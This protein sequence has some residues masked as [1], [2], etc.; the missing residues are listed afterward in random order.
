MVLGV[1]HEADYSPFRLDDVIG[2]KG[3]SILSNVDSRLPHAAH[4]T[5]SRRLTSGGFPRS[6]FVCRESVARF[7]AARSQYEPRP[8]PWHG[9]LTR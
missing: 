9:T 6:V 2:L 8:R 5:S 4:R 3:E 1:E 7:L